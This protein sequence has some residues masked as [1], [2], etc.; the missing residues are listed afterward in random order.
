MKTFL[1]QGDSITDS[2]RRGDELGGGSYGYPTFVEGMLGAKYPNVFKFVNKGVSGNRSVDMFARVKRD[3]VNFKPDI[4]TVL[5]GVNDVWHELRDNAMVERNGID[6]DSYFTYYD[7]FISFVRKMSPQTEIIILEPFVLKASG[8]EKYWSVFRREVAK[9]AE[10]ARNL[11]EKYGLSFI[12]LQE[13][14]DKLSES[15][16]ASHWLA[17]GVHPAPA[18][19]CVIAKKIVAAVESEY[20]EILK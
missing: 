2:G 3:T 19:H 12:P 5:I 13:T 9:R 11:A 6:A 1:F 14:F 4:L 17:D 10:K 8:T 15:A 20:A 7:M 16:P 18:G